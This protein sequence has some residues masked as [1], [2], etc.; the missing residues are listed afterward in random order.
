MSRAAVVSTL[1]AQRLY[2]EEIAH[3]GAAFHDQMM[4]DLEMK[5]AAFNIAADP[6]IEGLEEGAWSRKQNEMV[7]AVL[8]AGGSPL[9]P[10]H[11]EFPEAR[12]KIARA[13]VWAAAAP[14][15]WTA[16]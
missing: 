6:W 7:A 11:P 12:D 15:F 8:A 5:G 4:R 2:R 9:S 16:R 3:Q 1:I 10:D 13:F 14:D